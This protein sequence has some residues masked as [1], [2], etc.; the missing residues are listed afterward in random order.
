MSLNI[1]ASTVTLFVGLLCAQNA[2]AQAPGADPVSFNFE[3]AFALQSSSDL[4]DVEGSFSVNRWYAGMGVT[5]S[6]DPRNSL[7]LYAG[8]G[9]AKYDFDTGTAMGDGMPWEEIHE[10]R[11][12][13]IGRFGFGETGSVFLIPTARH[14][15]EKDS[16]TGDGRTYG[17]FAAAAWRL[18]ESLTI[19]PGFG[20]FSKIED[21]TRFFPILVIDWQISERWNLSTSRGLAASQ[22]PGV[23]LNYKATET[24]TFGLTSR[25]ENL[26]FRLDEDG[27]TPG[28]IGRDQS[29][30]AVLSAAWEPDKHVKLA[31]FAGLEFAGKLKLKNAQDELLSESNYDPAPIYGG[32]FE[33]RF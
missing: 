22:G 4:S 32:T 25:Y 1:K 17:L 3:G 10:T 21:G 5:Y 23:T 30:P 12:S 20:I 26:E 27:T 31:L 11:I 7:G 29:I 28:G 33:L 13:L 24:W 15:G 18:N 19:G 8:G 16:D 2:L 9:S 6:W 14:N